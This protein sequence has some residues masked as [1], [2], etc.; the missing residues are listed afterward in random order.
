MKGEGGESGR[1]R[2]P[3]MNCMDV[4]PSLA[5]SGIHH[6]LRIGSTPTVT[7]RSPESGGGA[8]RRF[9]WA[10]V[11]EDSLRQLSHRE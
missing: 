7:H 10:R 3:E 4:P 8:L 5:V 1:A 11:G 9:G 2:G 6:E